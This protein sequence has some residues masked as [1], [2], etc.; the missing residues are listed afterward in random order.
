[1]ATSKLTCLLVLQLATAALAT[2]ARAQDTVKLDSGEISGVV[3]TKEGAEDVRVFKGIPY[4]APPVG[5]LR[6]KPPQRPARWEGVRACAAFG[7]ACPQPAI[8]LMGVSEKQSED[9]LF[10]NVWTPAKDA[11]AK[12]P[13]MFWIHGGS[14]VFGSGAQDVYAGEAL[15]RRGVVVVTINYRL[16][17]FG[18]LSHPGLSKEGCP[19]NQGLLDQVAALEWVKR[20]IAA[21]GGDPGCVTIFG[22]SAGGGS[23][24]A[25]LL[26]PLAKGLFHRAISQSGVCFARPLRAGAYG[27]EPAEKTGERLADLLGCAESDDPVASMRA[28]S[29]KELL[30]AAKP[31]MNPFAGEG[32]TFGLVVDGV[33]ITEDPFALMA[34]GKTADVPLLV[35]TTADEGT[36]FVMMSPLGNSKASLRTFVETIFGAEA[37]RILAAYP[38]ETDAEVKPSLARLL[39]DALFI[40]PARAFIRSRSGFNSKSFLYTFTRVSPGAKSFGLGAYHG[41]ELRYVF[42][43][44]DAPGAMGLTKD[45]RALGKKMSAAWVR[46]A[47]TG[48]PNGEG[49]P[50]WPAYTTANDAHLE[51]GDTVREGNGLHRAECDLF[52]KVWANLLTPGKKAAKR[53]F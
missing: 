43:T 31:A 34:K 35:G 25:L 42:D 3:A 40:G 46:F 22:E 11:S 21:F 8:P 5:A 6:W 29:A 28:K 9:C 10:A 47:K 39:G 36:I 44:F 14:F 4:A 1:M 32:L 15:A 17:P 16:G 20:N 26:S 45:D 53:W 2:S 19:G 33:A 51:L 52:D 18:F 37:D 27:M 41:S 30:A 13:V 12:L 38:A 48:D 24:V 49:I 7:P 50:S 23:V